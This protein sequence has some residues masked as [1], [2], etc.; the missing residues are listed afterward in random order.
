MLQL[1]SSL[2]TVV[3]QPTVKELKSYLK[4][5]LTPEQYDQALQKIESQWFEGDCF[6]Q[7]PY[8]KI[9]GP[10]KKDRQ[11]DFISILDGCAKVGISQIVIPS[12]TRP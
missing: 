9:L 1:L 2:T 12:A 4:I 10:E 11:N 3:L 6:M 7:S 5:G 8:W